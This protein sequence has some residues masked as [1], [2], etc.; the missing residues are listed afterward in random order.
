MIKMLD[1][2]QRPRA[3]RPR[4]AGTLRISGLFFPNNGGRDARGPAKQAF[5]K[6]QPTNSR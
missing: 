4:V 1:G 5:R 2:I 6:P 3:S